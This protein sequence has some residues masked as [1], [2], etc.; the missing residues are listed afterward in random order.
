MNMS[1][2]FSEAEDG[3]D[4]REIVFHHNKIDYLEAESRLKAANVDGS[5]LT[6][7]HNSRNG[8]NVFILSYMTSLSGIKHVL[9][10]HICKLQLMHHQKIDDLSR[11]VF[12]VIDSIEECKFPLKCNPTENHPVTEST[13][14]QKTLPAKETGPNPI[15]TVKQERKDLIQTLTIKNMTRCKKCEA[16]LTPDCR[17]C[18][19][20]Y[21]MKKYGGPGIKKQTCLLRPKCRRNN[22]E[23]IFSFSHLKEGNIKE[24]DDLN[25]YILKN[26][27]ESVELKDYAED[28]SKNAN[29]VVNFLSPIKNEDSVP[30]S[31]KCYVCG[32]ESYNEKK[33]YHHVETHKLRL[34]QS[35]KKYI[36]LRKIHGHIDF[37]GDNVDKKYKCNLCK[38]AFV[39]R[40]TLKRHLTIHRENSC[41]HCG[42]S[43]SNPE[44]LQYHEKIHNGE[45]Q[46]T[47]DQCSMSF[48]TLSRMY[49]HSKCKHSGQIRKKQQ[50]VYECS[51]CDYKTKIKAHFNR[52]LTTVKPHVPPPIRQEDFSCSACGYITKFKRSL[53]RHM[54]RCNIKNTLVIC[55]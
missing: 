19:F 26:S 8:K 23:K 14:H 4:A 35:C 21:D 29:F 30:V 13:L 54:E 43:F 40:G 55:V 53:K 48:A 41:S 11:D 24:S 18:K 5:Y 52:H 9:I 15:S 25:E 6:R 34:C 1:Q 31:K 28:D 45:K 16:C 47:C 3:P 17:S 42:K 37:C 32:F 10:P 7:E 46:F 50:K 36:N 2:C 20:C 38:S 33:F 39:K 12:S 51:S 44:R 27:P 22:Q 49:R